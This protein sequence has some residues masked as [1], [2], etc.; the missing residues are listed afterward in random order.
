MMKRLLDRI[1][2]PQTLLIILITV[3]AFGGWALIELGIWL[4]GKV[5]S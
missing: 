1:T 4:T 2:D 5:W 3:S